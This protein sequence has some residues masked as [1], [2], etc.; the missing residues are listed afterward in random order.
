MTRII[1]NSEDPELRELAKEDLDVTTEGLSTTFSTLE[2]ALMPRHPQSHLPALME[3]RSGI[4]GDEANIFASDILKMYQ[5]YAT[6]QRWEVR[7]YSI[8]KTEIG[9]GVTEAILA[10]SGPDAFGKLKGEAGVH[11]V[12]RT[13]ATE[14]KGRTHTSTVSVNVFPEIDESNDEFEF[15]KL[16]MSEIKLEVMRSRGAGGQHVN[17]TESAVR[18]THL[19]TGLSISMQDSRSQ[20]ANKRAAFAILRS[21][22]SA[23]RREAAAEKQVGMRRSQ[24]SSTDRSEKIR[25]Y[26]YAQS[27]VTDH[28]CG[29]SSHDLEGILNGTDSLDSLLER[30]NEWIASQELE[31]QLAS[32]Q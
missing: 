15:E 10:I 3:I 16:D 7:I 27:R 17:R 31:A 28:R 9:D 5:N 14:S 24:V 19:P 30:V 32:E 2:K 20:H 23:Q 29:Y 4:G 11:R 1:A 8:T 21:K 22:L 26:N 12:Q 25:T 6:S 18:L 13:P